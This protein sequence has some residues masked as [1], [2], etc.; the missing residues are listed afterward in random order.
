MPLI[1]PT[2]LETYFSEILNRRYVELPNN[3]L[4]TILIPVHDPSK[5]NPAGLALPSLQDTLSESGN[6]RYWLITN[7]G[8]WAGQHRALDEVAELLLML[9][10]WFTRARPDWF[11]PR[12]LWYPKFDTDD[13]RCIWFIAEYFRRR[14]ILPRTSD[15]LQKDETL[16]EREA[17]LFRAWALTN[18]PRY[19]TEDRNYFDETIEQVEDELERGAD[20]HDKD[21]W[22]VEDEDE[23]QRERDV[24][25]KLFGQDG[26]EGT[27]DCEEGVPMW[28]Q[29]DDIFDLRNLSI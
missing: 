18:P 1:L 25:D 24:D 28:R 7:E 10:C 13:P 26:D 14:L 11:T 3:A 9:F 21:V 29:F 4:S 12:L 8:M 15:T 19:E 22:Q 17:R 6:I 16:S 5:Y 2:P 23:S 20:K 27:W